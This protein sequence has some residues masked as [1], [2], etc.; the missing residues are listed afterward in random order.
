VKILVADRSRTGSGLRRFGVVPS[1]RAPPR[2]AVKARELD[3]ARQ[4]RPLG[5]SSSKLVQ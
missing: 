1:R 5:Q 4:A 3:A 2:Q